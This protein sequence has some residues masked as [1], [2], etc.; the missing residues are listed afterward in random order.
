MG[1]H[2]SEDHTLQQKVYCYY[3][4]HAALKDELGLIINI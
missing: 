2:F 4:E 1:I 3:H